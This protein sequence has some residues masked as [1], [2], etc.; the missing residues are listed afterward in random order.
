MSG[1]E[2]ATIL[3]NSA[4]PFAKQMLATHGEFHPYGAYL[5]IGGAVTDVGVKADGAPAPQKI[6][7]LISAF[8]VMANDPAI[9]AFAVVYNVSIKAPDG[10]VTDAIQ[11]ALEHRDG[12]RVDILYPYPLLSG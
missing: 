8:R 11:V 2:D 10:V 1:K 9:V 12:Y 7:S 5:Q 4:V 3:M 6:N